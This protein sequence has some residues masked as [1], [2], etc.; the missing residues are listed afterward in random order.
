MSIVK[1]TSGCDQLRPK[2]VQMSFN[3]LKL[4][5]LAIINRM[6]ETVITPYKLK[7]DIVRPINRKIKQNE[8]KQLQAHRALFCYREITQNILF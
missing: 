5:F 4:V 6:L 2:Y 7:V 1:K 3:N 8:V